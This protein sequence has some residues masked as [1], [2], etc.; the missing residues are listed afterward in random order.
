MDTFDTINELVNIL[1]GWR[2]ATSSAMGIQLPPIQ[3]RDVMEMV[4][5]Q[6][7]ML[8][9]VINLARKSPERLGLTDAV[10]D[11]FTDNYVQMIRDEWQFL[12]SDYIVKDADYNALRK[13]FEGE[14]T[15]FQLN[16][17]QRTYLDYLAMKPDDFSVDSGVGFEY[18]HDA[19]NAYNIHEQLAGKLTRD[20]LFTR[21]MIDNLD[22][23]VGFYPARW[24][25]TNVLD[26]SG[27][28]TQVPGQSGEGGAQ[29]PGEGIEM[30]QLA[31]TDEQVQDI[32]GELLDKIP[33][34]D[35]GA[36]KQF[37]RDNYDVSESDV[38]NV[39]DEFEDLQ[40][41]NQFR[42][43][44]EAEYDP[45]P[46]GPDPQKPVEMVEKKT[47]RKLMKELLKK[48]PRPTLQDMEDFAKENGLEGRNMDAFID[49]TARHISKMMEEIGDYG[50]DFPALAEMAERNPEIGKLLAPSEDFLAKY[51]GASE[52][53]REIMREIRQKQ[54]EG[55]ELDRKLPYQLNEDGS[56]PTIEQLMARDTGLDENMTVEELAAALMA[57]NKRVLQDSPYWHIYNESIN[58]REAWL[59]GQEKEPRMMTD[60]EVLEALGNERQ[61]PRAFDNEYFENMSA[62]EAEGYKRNLIKLSEAEKINLMNRMAIDK[63]TG[64]FIGT[65]LDSQIV[66][67]FSGFSS[68]LGKQLIGIPF[69]G[70]LNSMTTSIFGSDFTNYMNW[71][72]GVGDLLRGD[73]TGLLVQ[74]AMTLINEEGIQHKRDVNNDDPTSWKY[75]RMGYVRDVGD[76]KWYP[77]YVDSRTMFTGGLGGRKGEMTM[78]YGENP[79]QFEDGIYFENP[80]KKRFFMDDGEFEGTKW[81][82]TDTIYDFHGLN[83]TDEDI[84]DRAE[85]Y[86]MDSYDFVKHAAIT[87][88]WFF[89]PEGQEV[90]WLQGELPGFL[91]ET[92]EDAEGEGVNRN[93]YTRQIADWQR[94]TQ[95]QKE[96]RW[97]MDEQT[98]ENVTAGDKDFATD[99]G[100]DRVWKEAGVN[101]AD[102]FWTNRD[103]SED[104]I[105]TLVDNQGFRQHMM[106]E[107]EYLL[108]TI[109]RGSIDSLVLA[110]KA[111]AAEQGYEKYKVYDDMNDPNEK[112]STYWS[113]QYLDPLDIATARSAEELMQQ[114]EQIRAMD[115]RTIKQK[116]YLINRS[117]TRYWLGQADTR[118][119]LGNVAEYMLLDESMWD[120]WYKHPRYTTV[121]KQ[122]YASAKMPWA[123]ASD[124]QFF[125]DDLNYSDEYTKKWKG[126]YDDWKPQTHDTGEAGH[127]EWRSND[128]Q[129][130]VWNPDPDMIDA[131]WEQT[132]EGD[133]GQSYGDGTSGW[134]TGGELPEEVYTDVNDPGYGGWGQQQGVPD[135]KI[136]KTDPNWKYNWAENTGNAPGETGATDTGAT[137]TGATDNT[138]GDWGW[139]DTNVINDDWGGAGWGGQFGNSSQPPEAGM[140]WSDLVGGWVFPDEP[141]EDDKTPPEQIVGNEDLQQ[142]IADDYDPNWKPHYV[143]DDDDDTPPDTTPTPQD[144]TPT[145]Q[146][147]PE[148]EPEPEPVQPTPTPQGTPHLNQFGEYLLHQHMGAFQNVAAGGTDFTQLLQQLPTTA[149]GQLAVG[150]DDTL[151]DQLNLPEDVRAV[152]VNDTIQQR[153]DPYAA[154]DIA[155]QLNFHSS[156]HTT[157]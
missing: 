43:H 73:P 65:D 20:K 132:D 133:W 48:N 146:P 149:S 130:R 3:P 124:E 144:T 31:L 4:N 87:R 151:E 80:K 75:S 121:Q 99:R 63:G 39:F 27:G 74:T 136:D 138:D 154:T 9:E 116:D 77:A 127:T 25:K 148:P 40:I 53:E 19:A 93:S 114:H 145:P 104:D 135:Y 96:A 55:Y 12:P 129:V 126:W 156:S 86:N 79:V 119:G 59:A 22:V 46:T 24:D 41:E 125:P 68:W 54:L 95:M 82:P 107:N 34:A 98:N 72:L 115:D 62:L 30:T 108:D 37:I 51:F 56:Y 84:D 29:R 66:S 7:E 11:E 141:E 69:T 6:P 32:A 47:L 88:D 92:F 45:L 13:Y 14:N 89:I 139:T 61:K 111:A 85:S 123:L 150:G 143:G 2:D 142:D 33:Q 35:E 36:V 105:R 57:K 28:K 71:G 137:D 49:D 101:Y 157:L 97:Y 58:D 16:E 5:E 113:M 70:L 94:V 155:Q 38:E 131:G 122:S 134:G 102:A 153:A 60:E 83:Y 128:K 120:A 10:P 152:Q 17:R 67:K 18:E 140:V 100:F 52:E 81:N 44:N 8:Q 118:N 15:F 112:N 147:K 91:P 106:P 42:Q 117:T 103:I 23:D 76:G 26:S 109:L 110:Q 1:Q 90:N 78:I 50:D 21:D 64:A